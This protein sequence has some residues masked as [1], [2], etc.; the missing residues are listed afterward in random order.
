MTLEGELSAIFNRVSERHKVIKEIEQKKFK[1]MQENTFLEVHCIDWIEKL[2]DPNVTKLSKALRVTRGTIS[3][4]TKKLISDGLIEKYQKEK[5]K[6]EI[7][8]KLTEAGR[9]IYL[10]HQAMHKALLEKDHAFFSK[11]SVAEKEQLVM[12]LKKIYGEI[13]EELKKIGLDNYI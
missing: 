5:N 2:N 10:E 13:A 7:Y 4:I 12:I 1:F 3:K 9:E 8:Y 6:K 11:L